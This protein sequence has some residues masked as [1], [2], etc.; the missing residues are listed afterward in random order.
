MEVK[1]LM[2]LTFVKTFEKCQ[3]FKAPKLHRF[4]ISCDNNKIS[5]TEDHCNQKKLKRH[6]TRN[7]SCLTFFNSDESCQL[8]LQEEF[9]C[10]EHLQK[11]LQCRLLIYAL[12][13]YICVTT[14]D[15]QTYWYI[16]CRYM[17]SM[18]NFK[19]L[20]SIGITYVVPKSCCK[21]VD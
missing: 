10:F 19:D 6:G 1:V 17:F 5:F 7:C 4:I 8:F 21:C 18:L 14:F 12:L 16:L 15:C 2:V 20:L 13:K 11:K 3:R 9:S